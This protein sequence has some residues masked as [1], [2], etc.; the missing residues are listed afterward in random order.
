MKFI[1][2]SGGLGFIGSHTV[3]ELLMN[4]YNVIIIDN[5]IN[6]SIDILQKIIKI[7]NLDDKSRL[8]YYNIDICND[9]QLENLFIKYKIDSVIHFASLKAVGESIKKPLEYYYNNISGTIA[10]LQVMKNY[11]CK[12]IIFSSSATVYGNNIYPVNEEA[13]IG[14]G[15][16][17][18]YGKTKYML[19]NILED[20]YQ[21]DNSWSIVILRFFNPIG[22]H[23]SGIIGENPNDIPNN[24]FPY[25]L[26]V[27]V[28]KLDQLCI[29]GN[30]YNTIDGTCIRDFIHVVDLAKG[31]ILSLQKL[32]T[33]PNN[34][35][36]YNLGTGKGTSVLELINTFESVNH[37]SLKYKFIQRR[38]G[39]LSI[40]YANTEKAYKELGWKCQYTIEDMCR[41]GYNF[42]K[43][44]NNKKIKK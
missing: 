3:I 10:L 44:Y 25:L 28:G 35:Y 23:P 34:I 31:H 2:V 15:I 18:P 14:D 1:L 17:N 37:I 12:K 9:F 8:Q 40:V 39:D 36:V 27:S 38:E 20:L 30:D 7:T 6:S 33:D 41:D 29:F 5:L 42:I 4:N 19:E 16:T 13:K 26:K 32:N 11:D 21:S 22:A 43:N 24:L